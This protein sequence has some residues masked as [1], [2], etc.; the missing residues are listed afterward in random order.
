M[1]GE[2]AG[3]VTGGNRVSSQKIE[4]AGFDFQFA[5]ISPALKDLIG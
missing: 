3:I 5:E 2:M 1:M 4:K